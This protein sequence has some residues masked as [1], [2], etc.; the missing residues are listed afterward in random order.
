[1]CLGGDVVDVPHYCTVLV[2]DKKIIRTYKLLCAFAKGVPIVST[3]WLIDS[4]GGGKFLSPELFL[5]RDFDFEQRYNIKFRDSLGDSSFSNFHEINFNLT[6]NKFMFLSFQQKHENHPFLKV[7]R[8]TLHQISNHYHLSYQVIFL[9][10]LV[11]SIKIFTA[12][13]FSLSTQRLFNA[14][15]EL[16]CRTIQTN[17]MIQVM[18][19]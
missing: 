5:T 8:S 13:S 19:I 9:V 1:M 6:N 17:L 3:K 2:T 7:I 10:V 12:F 14:V 15:E 18:C 11:K 4:N 16:L